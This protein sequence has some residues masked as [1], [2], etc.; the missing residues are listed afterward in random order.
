MTDGTP[1]GLS[2]IEILDSSREF[3]EAQLAP[4]VEP[5]VAICDSAPGFVETNF[6]NRK[7]KFVSL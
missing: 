1:E 4:K 3:E 7:S 2:L 6:A 5:S